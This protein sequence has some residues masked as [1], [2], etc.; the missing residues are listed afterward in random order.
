MAQRSG[1]ERGGTA[2]QGAGG[3]VSPPPLL[4]SARHP[5]PGQLL[6]AGTP[7]RHA[8]ALPRVAP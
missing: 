5:E 2:A 6:H 7:P 8:R 3:A 4:R 1:V